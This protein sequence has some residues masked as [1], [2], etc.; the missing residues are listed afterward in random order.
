[1]NK[2]VVIE[3]KEVSPGKQRKAADSVQFRKMLDDHKMV[4][5]YLDGKISKKELDSKGIRLVKPL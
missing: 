5:A 4:H 3:T 2:S 1:M